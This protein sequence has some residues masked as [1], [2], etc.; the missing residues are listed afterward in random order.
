MRSVDEELRSRR[1]LGLLFGAGGMALVFVPAI[2]M[3][4]VP[5]GFSVVAIAAMVMGIALLVAGFVTLP[6]SLGN[7]LRPKS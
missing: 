3:L 6:G 4:F 7:I 1:K 2:L 5:G